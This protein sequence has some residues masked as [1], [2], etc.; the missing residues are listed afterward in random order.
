[1]DKQLTL[2]QKVAF[3]KDYYSKSGYIN[4]E[5]RLQNDVSRRMSA[6]KTREEAIDELYEEA[7]NGRIVVEPSKVFPA[8]RKQTQPASFRSLSA[9]QNA[10]TQSQASV[11]QPKEKVRP[12]VLF[13][14]RTFLENASKRFSATYSD[15]QVFIESARRQNISV[16]ELD[17]DE[18]LPWHRLVADL[19]REEHDLAKDVAKVA[20]FGVLGSL[21]WNF[22]MRVTRG[23]SFHGCTFLLFDFSVG[24]LKTSVYATLIFPETS[25]G[26]N[27]ML[28]Y[29]K[30]LTS[31]DSVSP[32]AERT[33]KNSE[34]IRNRMS[35][36]A[37]YIE[38]FEKNLWE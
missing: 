4:L 30:T 5:L 29:F 27:S 15:G 12:F 8:E 26:K 3:I 24:V 18:L 1:M 14:D 21:A 33:W 28:Q 13:F 19:N 9:E 23:L 36:N 20:V 6:G 34:K 37:P 32:I 2:D 35:K 22:P 17:E 38:G 25:I 31:E 7:K 16:K 10:R 11:A